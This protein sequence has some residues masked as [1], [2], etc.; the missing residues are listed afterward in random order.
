MAHRPAGRQ[1]GRLQLLDHART[2]LSAPAPTRAHPGERPP[3]Y[4]RTFARTFE[5]ANGSGTVTHPGGPESPGRRCD[6]REHGQQLWH[7]PDDHCG[8]EFA[9]AKRGEATERQQRD[10]REA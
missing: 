2:A 1:A 8:A 4:A 9:Q 7:A 3:G 10:G 5:S 6:P